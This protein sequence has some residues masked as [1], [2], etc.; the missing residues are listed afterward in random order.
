MS[1]SVPVQAAARA[2]DAACGRRPV[3]GV[4]EWVPATRRA[5]G[6]AIANGRSNAL[7]LIAR[8]DA[9]HADGPGADLLSTSA[10]FEDGD[11]CLC[12]LEGCRVDREV[13][14]GVTMDDVV[15]RAGEA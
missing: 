13:V 3:P 9:T 8:R 6:S 10:G 1:N 5:V 15:L 4:A 11:R 12:R 7:R 2:H 14:A